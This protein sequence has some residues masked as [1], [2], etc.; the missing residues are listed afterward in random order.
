MTSNT[1][2]IVR[3]IRLAMAVAFTLTTLMA[4]AALAG[5][6]WATSMARDAGLDAA[7][8]GIQTS[9][10]HVNASP[11]L[12]VSAA[13]G[14]VLFDAP[15]DLEMWAAGVTEIEYEIDSDA[16][17]ALVRFVVHHEGGERATF[18]VAAQSVR[19]A[20]LIALSEKE[21]TTSSMVFTRTGPDG[22]AW[23]PALDNHR[24]LVRPAVADYWDP[25][26]S[27]KTSSLTE[28]GVAALALTVSNELASV[29]DP[30]ARGESLSKS[31]YA[32]G[33][34]ERDLD[35]V[36]L[37]RHNA[38]V[39]A[40]SPDSVVEMLAVVREGRLLDLSASIGEAH[41][42]MVAHPHRALVAQAEWSPS[43]V[44]RS[45]PGLTTRRA[46]HDDG[47]Y[48]PLS[49]VERVALES[50][51]AREQWVVAGLPS[52]FPGS[53]QL[54]ED[55]WGDLFPTERALFSELC[56]AYRVYLTVIIATHSDREDVRNSITRLLREEFVV[57]ADADGLGKIGAD[58]D[59]IVKQAAAFARD[60]YWAR[61]PPRDPE[62]ELPDGF[63]FE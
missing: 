22:L 52:S 15:D 53:E 62:L 12:R 47:R 33:S 9:S 35:E 37:R 3:G 18:D 57:K 44:F 14:G 61:L 4:S 59:E 21:G 6:K 24:L 10:R 49:Y 1:H 56:D 20:A 60:G 55:F 2:T 28:F 39:N 40:F 41:Q 45:R 63:A 27:G 51:Q 50:E 46:L 36:A 48:R 42:A 34:L 32:Y 29:D 31:I 25:R 8:Q 58:S 43:F 13:I 38:W 19:R 17:P 30:N 26:S 7:V 5:G 16:T 23:H 54:D 11:R